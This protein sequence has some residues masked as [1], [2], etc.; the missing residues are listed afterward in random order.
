[1]P[2]LPRLPRI[3]RTELEKKQPQKNAVSKNIQSSQLQIQTPNVERRGFFE[4][5]SKSKSRKI[6]NIRAKMSSPHNSKFQLMRIESPDT[7]VSLQQQRDHKLGFGVLK[8]NADVVKGI[9]VGLGHENPSQVQKYSI[10]RLLSSFRL[11]VDL[12]FKLDGQFYHWESDR[13]WKVSVISSTSHAL[14]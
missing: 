10:T 8:L 4:A 3:H 1:M 14:P 11:E 9:Q 6:S 2:V 12:C 5:Y 7:D 13:Q